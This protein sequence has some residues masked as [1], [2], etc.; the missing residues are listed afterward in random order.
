MAGIGRFW[1]GAGSAAMLSLGGLVYAGSSPAATA[2]GIGIDSAFP[3]E[4]NPGGG[5]PKASLQ[6]AAAFAWQ[7][8]IALNWPVKVDDLGEPVR[9]TPAP[10]CLFGEGKGAPD[11]SK[12]P[13][14]WETFRGK[15]EIF[16]P[17]A[18]DHDYRHRPDYHDAYTYK[19]HSCDPVALDLKP[20]WVNVDETSEIGFDSMYAGVNPAGGSATNLDRQLIRFAAKA[21]KA[22]FEVASL[23][24]NSPPTAKKPITLSNGTVELKA[25]WRPLTKHEADSGRFHMTK[26]RYYENTGRIVAPKTPTSPAVPGVCWREA[27]WGLVGLHI[28]QKTPSAP[29]FIFATFEQADNI[30]NPKGE[31]VEDAEGRPS[32]NFVPAGNTRPETAITDG[33]N[34]PGQPGGPGVTIKGSAYCPAGADGRPKNQLYYVNSAGNVDV[35]TGGPICINRRDRHIPHEI[36]EANQQAHQAIASYNRSNGVTSPWPYYKLVNVQFKPLTKTVPGR[37]YTGRDAATYYMANSVIE[38]NTV[39]QNFSGGFTLLDGPI[40]DFA[41]ND[42]M[43]PPTPPKSAIFYNVRVPAAGG[44]VDSYL[45]GG[46]MGC[47]GNAQAAGGDFSFILLGLGQEIY[48]DSVPAYTPAGVRLRA[49]RPRT[50]GTPRGTAAAKPRSR[51]SR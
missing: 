42:V 39:L 6:Q 26:V 46:C 44:K 22:E 30:L 40:S 18:F 51:K 21:N 43:G 36:V 13:L 4:L 34:P 7:E 37:P 24:R 48:P 47:H 1:V 28:I 15:V 35:P 3:A 41:I 16:G 8:F 33:P 14:T 38:T 9:D 31:P 17:R 27:V 32:G 12:R 19:V 20:A 23:N 5:A 45:M 10:D 50:H 49:I 2:P 29:Y 11:C 25:A